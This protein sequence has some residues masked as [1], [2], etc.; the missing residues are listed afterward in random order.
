MKVILLF[1]LMFP[2][3]ARGLEPKEVEQLAITQRPGGW[4]PETALF[5]DGNGRRVSLRELSAGLPLIVILGYFNCQNLCPLTRASAYRAL[6]G[7]NLAAGRDYSL[8]AVS[9]DPQELSAAAQNVKRREVLDFSPGSS[10]A[11]HYLTGDQRAIN[12]LASAVG[13]HDRWDPD[14]RQFLHPAGLIVATKDGRISSYLLG[15]GYRPAAMRE[16][17]QRASSP[18]AVPGYVAPILLLCFHYDPATGRYSLATLKVLRVAAAASV[19]VLA[20]I[21][22]VLFRGERRIR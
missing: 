14:A 12:T 13:F 8:A 5:Q 3:S 15:V 7:A 20:G 21:V 4:L 6:V 9:I 19:L 16:A 18:S 17:L 10:A 1:L 2:W 11:I 22:L